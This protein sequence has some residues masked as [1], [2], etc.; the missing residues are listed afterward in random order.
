MTLNDSSIS[1]ALFLGFIHEFIIHVVSLGL[2]VYE[3]ER[4]T[5]FPPWV[6]IL[7][8]LCLVIHPLLLL[9]HIQIPEQM[10]L[11]AKFQD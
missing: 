5:R 7:C 3:T 4:E 10:S 8:S 11:K 6:L 1:G 2:G 9:F